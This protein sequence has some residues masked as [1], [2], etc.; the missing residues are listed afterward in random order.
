MN[1]TQTH[2][3]TNTFSKPKNTSGFIDLKYL[4]GEADRTWRGRLFH[5]LGHSLSQLFQLRRLRSSNISR[6]KL[7]MFYHS[8]EQN[9]N[10]HGEISV[11]Y[12]PMSK[13]ETKKLALFGQTT[14]KHPDYQNA[15]RLNGS[16]FDNKFKDKESFCGGCDVEKK[17]ESSHHNENLREKVFLG[18]I[19]SCHV[20]EKAV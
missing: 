1:D 6:T 14:S 18:Q 12:A 5:Y 20:V 8:V 7:S 9:K 2:D 17:K 4:M 13:D 16:N 11:P 10:D 15:I 19:S 3:K